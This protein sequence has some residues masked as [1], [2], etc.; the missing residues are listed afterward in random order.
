MACIACQTMRLQW[1]HQTFMLLDHTCLRDRPVRSVLHTW[2]H[3]CHDMC[4]RTQALAAGSDYLITLCRLQNMLVMRF[5]NQFMSAIWDN[6]NIANVQISMKEDFGTEGRGGYY[7][8]QGVIRDVMQNHLLQVRGTRAVP[9]RGPSTCPEGSIVQA[10]LLQEGCTLGDTGASQ[11]A[12]MLCASVCHKCL[13]LLLCS[14]SQSSSTC[15]T[16]QCCATTCTNQQ[17]SAVSCQLRAP[18]IHSSYHV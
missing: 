17:M 8:S 15:V 14:S 12:A 7:D 3:Q 13:H 18:N 16:G 11:H 2:R 4:V 9:C 5:S 6:K 10:H 1:L